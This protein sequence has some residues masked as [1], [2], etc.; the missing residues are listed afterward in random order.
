MTCW[1]GSPHGGAELDAAEE[2]LAKEL[3]AVRA[4]GEELGCAERVLIRLNA[5]IEAEADETSGPA[6]GQVAGPAV[7]LVPHREKG[8]DG[9]AGQFRR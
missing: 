8:M 6:A 3:E 4:E 2:R 9:T 1:S 7:L 5:Q